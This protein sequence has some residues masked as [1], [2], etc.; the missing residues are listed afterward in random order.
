MLQNFLLLIPVV[1][2]CVRKLDKS[3]N[4]VPDSSFENKILIPFTT[5]CKLCKKNL[6]LLRRLI[7]MNHQASHFY[8]G[9]PN[10]GGDLSRTPRTFDNYNNYSERVRSFYTELA[11]D[12]F[13]WTQMLTPVRM[14]LAGLYYTG[15]DDKVKCF[16]C[17][18]VLG[19]WTNTDDPF[20]EHAIHTVRCDF[21]INEGRKSAGGGIPTKYMLIPNMSPSAVEQVIANSDQKIHELNTTLDSFKCVICYDRIAN[22]VTVPCNHLGICDSCLAQNERDDRSRGPNMQNKCVVCRNKYDPNRTII[23]FRCGL[24]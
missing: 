20:L 14:A 11:R 18:V 5:K 13:I 22:V 21:L 17:D 8:Q 2:N 6:K 24:R 12:K 7:K 4:I 9:S 1:R 23:L 15:V 10:R 19:E 3:T 16:S